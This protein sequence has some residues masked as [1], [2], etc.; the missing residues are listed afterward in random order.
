MSHLLVLGE[1]WVGAAVA[2]AA[3]PRHAVTVI[4]PP[5]HPV[6]HQRDTQSELEL[7]KL[8]AQQNITMVINACGRLRGS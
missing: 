4:D 6:F 1:G 3:A 8:I 5:F 2:N 7:R